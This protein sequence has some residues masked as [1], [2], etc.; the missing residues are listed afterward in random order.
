M[1][2]KGS[3]KALKLN[4]LQAR[5]HS[6]SAQDALRMLVSFM[7]VRCMLQRWMPR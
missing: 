3:P 7:H 6:Q 4:S 1:L 2:G 5:E